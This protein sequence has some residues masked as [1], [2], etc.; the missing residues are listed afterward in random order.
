MAPRLVGWQRVGGQACEHWTARSILKEVHARYRS[1]HGG[2]SATPF[3]DRHLRGRPR[4]H[5]AATRDSPSIRF[6]ANPEQGEL[7]IR[8]LLISTAAAILTAL[9]LPPLTAQAYLMCPSGYSCEYNWWSDAAHTEIVGWMVVDCDGNSFSEG[10]HT[11]FLE[12]HKS[13]C[14]I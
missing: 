8:H 12:F 3:G 11:P 7:V 6:A 10:P 14:N 2:L 13:R 1:G 4:R 5:S 9:A